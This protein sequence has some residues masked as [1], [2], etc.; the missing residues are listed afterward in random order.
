MAARDS[1]SVFT[2]PQITR[3]RSA[4]AALNGQTYLSGHWQLQGSAYL[5]AFR[6]SHLDGNL[7]DFES[8]STRSSF[9]GKLC[10]QDDAFGTPP[11][12]KTT[13][14]RDQFVLLDGAGSPIA[15]SSSA[16]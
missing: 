6:Q 16:V 2:W 14:F 7:A 1:A 15:F 11:G 8:C 10:L 13:S 12:G 9:A 3:N 4:M 5:R